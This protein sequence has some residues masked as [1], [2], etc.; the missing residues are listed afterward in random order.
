[1]FS[2]VSAAIFVLLLSFGALYIKRALNTGAADL[3]LQTY[4]IEGNTGNGSSG[5]RLRVAQ[6]SDIHYSDAEFLKEALG[7]AVAFVGECQPDVIILTGDYVDRRH[8]PSK[9]FCEEWVPV[10][11]KVSSAPIFATLGNH[12]RFFPDEISNNLSMSGVTVLRNDIYS[13][14]ANDKTYHITG[15][16]D[17]TQPEWRDAR[18]TIESALKRSNPGDELI[19]LSHNPD[20]ARHIHPWILDYRQQTSTAT[21]AVIFSGHTHGGQICFPNGAP[22]L[23]SLQRLFVYLPFSSNFRIF[24]LANVVKRWQWAFGQ[25]ELADKLNLIVSRGVGSHQGLRLFCPPDVTVVDL[26]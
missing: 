10:L 17:I 15:L 13:L 6:L 7:K 21:P 5:G 1:M 3:R 4:V 2:S 26:H 24:R 11:K 14:K 22:V 12:D 8:E 18:A 20:T 16:V 9:K 19:I 25:Y 23:A